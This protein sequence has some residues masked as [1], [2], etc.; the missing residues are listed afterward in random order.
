MVRRAYL[1]L[2][3][4]LLP[5]V[6]VLD[7]V[8]GAEIGFFVFYFGPVAL[9]SWY[10]GRGWGSVMALAGAGLWFVVDTWD[11]QRYAESWIG[12][13][14]AGIRLV[15]F[16][17]LAGVTDRIRRDRD[18]R[19]ALNQQLAGTVAELEASLARVSALRNDIQVICA[20]TKRIRSEGRWMQFDEFL[21]RQLQVRVSHGISEEA[22]AQLRA[23][24]DSAGG[25]EPPG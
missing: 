12:F 2:A 18:R 6:A 25:G 5:I 20:W 24:I 21:Q 13:W 14:N 1:S 11:G 3:V 15:A 9:A 8:T 4:V 16:A 10:G 7:G 23:E 22:A 17:A 19:N